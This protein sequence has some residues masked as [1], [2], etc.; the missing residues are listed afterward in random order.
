MTHPSSSTFTLVGTEASLFTGKVRGYLR[1]KQVPFTE[2]LS[3]LQ[4]YRKVIVPRTGK[5]MIPVLL[6]PDDECIQDTTCIIDHLEQQYPEQSVY[7]SSPKQQLAA[8]LLECYGDEWLV[9]PAMHYRWQFKRYNLKFILKEFGETAFPQLPSPLHYVVGA[10]PA[11]AFGNRYKPYFGVTPNM[12]QAIERSYE[13]LLVELEAHFSQYPYLLGHRPSIGDYGFLGPFYAH[14]YRDPYPK[15]I[16][17]ARAPNVAKWVERMQFCTDAHYGEFLP[18]DEIPDT[19]LPILQR[20][21]REQFPVLEDTGKRLDQWVKTH[22][23]R[24]PVKRIIGEHHFSIEGQQSVRAITPF[25]YWMFQRALTVYNSHPQH[26]TTLDA[27]LEDI[28]G[29]RPFQ[30]Q[31][32]TRLAYEN[33][34]LISV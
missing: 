27:F 11:L 33:Y 13:A 3:S 23:S 18:N 16:L 8:M 21:T 4:V 26:K 20:M 28:K 7:P 17:N 34:R 24:Q 31:A 6:T 14:L 30:H 15:R 32:T 10:V 1:Y 29:T 9:M 19:L 25:S 22:G 12:E 5:Q 2:Q